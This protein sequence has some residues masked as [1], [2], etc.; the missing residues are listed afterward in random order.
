MKKIIDAYFETEKMNYEDYINFGVE[1]PGQDVRCAL[2]DDKIRSL[3][4][5]PTCVFDQEILGIVDYY[6]HKFI[7]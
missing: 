7:W 5:K 1:R 4:W 3:G 2:N 6:K